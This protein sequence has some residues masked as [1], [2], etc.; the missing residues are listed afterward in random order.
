MAVLLSVVGLGSGCHQVGG[1]R[2]GFAV[3]RAGIALVSLW[4]RSSPDPP[5]DTTC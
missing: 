2:D 5:S 4:F 1:Y 3:E